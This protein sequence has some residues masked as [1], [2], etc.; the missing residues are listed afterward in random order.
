MLED[1]CKVKMHLRGTLDDGRMF[2]DTHLQGGIPVELTLGEGTL[3]PALEREIAGMVPGQRLEV[4]IPAK[5]AY[6]EYDPS[7]REV[8]PV[9]KVPNAERLPVGEYIVFPT[10]EGLLRVKVESVEGGN[11]V[12][13]YNHELAGHD[14]TFRIDLVKALGPDGGVL[15]EELY[16]S[17]ADCGCK[18]LLGHDG[19]CH[20]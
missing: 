15:E 6:G 8:L 19:P 20:C 18:G 1:G 14:L 13:D 3:L 2:Y 16:R 17:E 9:S 4:R 10:D 11:V 5:D 12:F 7:L